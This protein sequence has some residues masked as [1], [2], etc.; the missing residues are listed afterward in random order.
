WWSLLDSPCFGRL[1]VIFDLRD[2][3]RE[4]MRTLRARS[5]RRT[6]VGILAMAA[7]IAI[8]ALSP[9]TASGA[10]PRTE[11][12]VDFGATL[13]PIAGFGFSAAFGRAALIRRLPADQQQQ[14]VNLLLSP[15]DGAGLS[16]LRLSI[17]SAPDGVGDNRSI[18]PVDPGGPAA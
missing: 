17:G 1:P 14:V 9:A 8:G 5:S 13:Q 10:P 18:E 4:R 11:G 6:A 3:R 2:H 15:K 12:S 7:V 16:I